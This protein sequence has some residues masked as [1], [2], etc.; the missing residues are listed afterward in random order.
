MAFFLF[1]DESGHDRVRS[2]YEVLAGIAVEDRDI[3]NLIEALNDA[4][5]HMFG[6][7]YSREIDEIKARKFLKRKVFR[8][9][10]QADTFQE[11]Q[12]RNLARG[13]LEAGP[14]A[15]RDQ[16]AALAQAKLAFVS[17]ALEICIRFHANAF[18]SIVDPASPIPA[19]NALRKDYAYLFER[20][21]YFL[22]DRRRG[23]FGAIVFDELEKSQSHILIAQMEEYFQRTAT[24]RA[25]A[26]QIIPEP[27]FVHSDLSSLIQI[28]DLIAY[29]VS[30]GFRIPGVMNVAGRAELTDLA[31]SVARL[32]YRT[33]RDVRGNPDFEVWSFSYID[34][35]RGRDERGD[36]AR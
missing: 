1:L 24:G 8:H 30:W 4:E 20:F 27:F 3:W 23:E 26:R 33:T 13:C 18:A 7:R 19:S 11:D 22:E 25:R 36:V 17:Q 10:G 15:T 12:R 9:A 28:A 32:R 31:R 5:E 21:Y 14:R 29:I 35:L 2:P 6:V 16:I 34:D